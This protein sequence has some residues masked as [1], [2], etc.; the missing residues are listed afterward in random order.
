M[1]SAEISPQRTAAAVRS[2]RAAAEAAL[3]QVEEAIAWMRR[4]KAEVSVAA[5]ARRAKVSRTFCYDNPQA[6]AAIAAAAA[7]RADRHRR[8]L[9][10]QDA[11]QEASWR[12]RALNAEGALT[13]AIAEIQNQRARIAEL[14]G[15]IRDLTDEWNAETTQR[16]TSENTTLKQR[17]RTL[18]TES[19]TLEERLS[20]ARSNLRFQDKR[21]AELEAHLA[22]PAAVGRS[23][24]PACADDRTVRQLFR[25]T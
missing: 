20:A 5:V 14:L 17:V 4:E 25:T 7:D 24:E 15:Q 10:D 21:I 23:Q 12:E 9:D 2:R 6:R 8:R 22:E 18:T 3:T 11:A 19:R 1:T 16:I 13:T